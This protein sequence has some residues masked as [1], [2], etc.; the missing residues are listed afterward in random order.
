MR[1][2]L[3]VAQ[4]KHISSINTHITGLVDKISEDSYTSK[5]EGGGGTSLT[6]SRISIIIR[7]KQVLDLS[8]RRHWR[9]PYLLPVIH[10]TPLI[11]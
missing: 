1:V 6:T 10:G 8:R 3:S 9:D 5:R 4:A 7:W 2:N 11:L